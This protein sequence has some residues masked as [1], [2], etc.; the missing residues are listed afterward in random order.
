[1]KCCD[2]DMVFLE[3]D[4]DWV[5]VWCSK[6]TKATNSV[7]LNGGA[8]GWTEGRLTITGG[9]SWILNRTALPDAKTVPEGT[10]MA[11]GT[12][13]TVFVKDGQWKRLP[14]VPPVPPDPIYSRE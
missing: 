10:M 7:L 8:G 5:C 13:G 3:E 1:M 11:D 4:Q 14:P 9:Q 2:D 6:I 12:G